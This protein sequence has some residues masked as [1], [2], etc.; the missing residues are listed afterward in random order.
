MM[1]FYSDQEK[2]MRVRNIWIGMLAVA[3]AA[4]ITACGGKKDDLDS[5]TGGSAAAT[6]GGGPKV[7]AAT[8]GNIEGVVSFEGV[9]PKNE[10]IRMNAD[11]VCV[12]ANATPQT[13]ETYEV[14][15]G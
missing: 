5:D 3:L 15:D 11:P 12:K 4:S 1:V 2:S 7:D 6:G 9:A 10:P 13:Q 8:A 14:A